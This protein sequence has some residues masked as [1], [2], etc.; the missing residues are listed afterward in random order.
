MN[1]QL[2]YLPF[3][4]LMHPT[5]RGRVEIDFPNRENAVS[6]FETLDK[7]GEIEEAK[8]YWPD[9]HVETLKG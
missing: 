5:S 3:I 6:H 1:C 2:V 7:L 8:I 9:G 4:T